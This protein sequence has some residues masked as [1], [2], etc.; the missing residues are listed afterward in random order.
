VG[1]EKSVRS[2]KHF[3]GKTPLSRRASGQGLKLG[4][5]GNREDRGMS[6]KFLRGRRKKKWEFSERYVKG[7]HRR[8]KCAGRGG[9]HIAQWR[10]KRRTR[11]EGSK[12]G[13]LTF[14]RKWSSKK[15]DSSTDRYV[16]ATTSPNYQKTARKTRRRYKR[17]GRGCPRPPLCLRDGQE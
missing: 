7:C 5:R 15:D 11:S 1:P 13:Y 16:T 6:R 14:N 17:G 12:I 2:N 4:E 3:L 10:R 9:R 8:G